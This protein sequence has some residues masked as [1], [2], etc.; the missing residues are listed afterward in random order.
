MPTIKAQFISSFSSED[1]VSCN[2]HVTVVVN[3]LLANSLLCAFSEAPCKQSFE[4]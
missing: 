3:V 1:P 4:L 2:K